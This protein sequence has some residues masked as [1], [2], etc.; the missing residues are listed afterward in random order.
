MLNDYV[1]SYVVCVQPG[2]S[3]KH[4]VKT[5]AEKPSAPAAVVSAIP[6]GSAEA[7]LKY[8]N[9]RLKLALAQRWVKCG[10]HCCWDGTYSRT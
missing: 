10:T 4:Q 7:Q 5:A 1:L 3:P 6:A 2:E 8:E 9:D